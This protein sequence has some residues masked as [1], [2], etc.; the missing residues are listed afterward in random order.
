VLAQSSSK[1]SNDDVNAFVNPFVGTGGHGHTY[2]G[3]T[4]P[5][6]MVQLSPDTRLDGWDGC[7]GYHYSDS[8]I[9]GFSHTHLQGTGVSDYGDILFMPTNHYVGSGNTWPEVYRSKFS[10]STE[11]A[12]PGYYSV[13]LND[14][15]I[16]AEL[17]AT[18]RVGIHKYTFSKGDSCLFFLDFMHRDE[19]RQY[20]FE[21]IGD[22]AIKGYRISK[23]WAEKQYC[24]FYAVFNKPFHGLEQLVDQKAYM[25]ENKEVKVSVEQLQLYTLK[26]DA[27]GE[28][29]VKVGLSGTSADA[30]MHNLYTEARHWDF[31]KYKTEA[32]KMW[33]N[34]LAKVSCP[35]KTIEEKQNFYSSLYHCYTTPNVWSDVDGQYLGMDFQIHQASGYQQ[36]TVFSLWDTFRGLHPLMA[37]LEPE[38]TLDFIKS[39]LA[40]YEQSGKLPVWELAANETNCMIGFHSVSVIADAYARGIKGFDTE[41]A[42]KAMMSSAA[43]PE[44][45]KVYF[46]KFGYVPSE[47][48]SESVS[49]TLEYAYD[50]WCIAQFAKAIGYE[51]EY[52]EC[53]KL[54]QNWKN[55]FDP[56][57]KFFR[58]RR[59]GGFTEDFD[60]FQVNFNY[61]EA[62]AWQYRFF[63]PQYPDELAEMMGGKDAL[64]KALD[65]LFSA[66][67]QTTG[68]EQADITG[69]IGQYAHGN[70]PSHHMAYLYGY[71]GE[72][73]KQDALVK[74]IMK[75]Q[76]SPT[77]DGL[78]GNEDCGQMS[79]WYV[80]SALGKYPLA[81]G[82]VPGAVPS[83]LKIVPLPII[84]GPLTSFSERTDI[85]F[86]HVDP[87]ARIEFQ[88]ENEE[89]RLLH[90]DTQKMPKFLLLE[91]ADI[92][93][94]AITANGDTSN[95]VYARFVKRTNNFSL[96]KSSTPDAQY[97]GG[98]AD[99]LVDGLMYGA[100][101]RTG[102]WQ[103][104][105]DGQVEFVVDL[106]KSTAVKRAGVHC[107]E[108]T[109]SWIWYP[110]VVW[111]DVSEDGVS[112]ARMAEVKH[113]A[114]ESGDLTGVISLAERINCNARYVKFTLFT[115]FD[116]IPEWHLG[117]G[118]KPWI[119]VDEIEIET[120][121]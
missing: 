111:I 120:E 73:E 51:A 85:R 110:G 34:K 53:M 40:M 49:K 97:T 2:P 95:W 41:A 39:F 98:G 29:M 80:L 78:C 104:F 87:T 15:R 81:P 6:G 11:V 62:N 69:L 106:G 21:I 68:R 30:A 14:Y 42:L 43:G 61:T 45:E 9:Y 19:L 60:P 18:P 20:D 94:R 96:F 101:F 48:F 103:G 109:K 121:P 102:G 84:Y 107:L 74:R 23:G 112:Y 58:A 25:D 12:S 54:S 72:K 77:P 35:L 86:G 88:H 3:A 75:E 93:A 33:R 63:V 71:F 31:G 119:F 10:H 65:D 13:V 55:V 64:L 5:F 52:T 38:C 116:T 114:V 24:Y 27:P 99:A 4:T 8:L 50:Y 117:S 70:E 67:S 82:G 57:T 92:Q 89:G 56:E 118:G 44:Q 16:K 108:E 26:F 105:R 37:E 7:G 90:Y 32:A 91:S 17:T 113:A 22:T 79:A 115:P 76:Y 47:L 36:Y 59:N 100:D 46:A 66:T 83:D 28:L 1:K